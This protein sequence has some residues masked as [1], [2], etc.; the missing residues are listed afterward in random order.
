MSS[1]CAPPTPSCAAAASSAATPPTHAGQPLPDLV[2]LAPDAREMTEEDWQR[3]DAHSVG[4]FLNGDAIAEPD[5]CGRPVVD[6]SFLLLLNSY[7]E[8]VEFRLPDVAYGERWTTLLDTADPGGRPDET[9]HKAGHRHEPSRRAAWSC[10]PGPAR[11]AER[12][13]SAL[14]A[15][16]HREL[17]AVRVAQHGL[18]AALRQDAAAVQLGGP[19][20]RRH[21]RDREVDLPVRPDA[22][23]S[24]ADPS[25]P[26]SMRATTSPRLRSTTS[27]P[28]YWTSQQPGRSDAQSRTSP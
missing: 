6:D 22:S 27:P 9:E 20:A 25:A 17:R 21:V 26:D 7:W 23:G 14:A 10:S 11:T 3:P 19:G 8:P 12:E 13:R 4:V 15:R 5:A 24:G 16:R 28:S 2:W 1:D 18:V